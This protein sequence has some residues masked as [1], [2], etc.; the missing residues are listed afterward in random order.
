MTLHP[1]TTSLYD[2]GTSPEKTFSRIFVTILAAVRREFS[3]IYNRDL[4]SS[5]TLLMDEILTSFA[6][7][8]GNGIRWWCYGHS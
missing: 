5:M 2:W 3:S 4:A 7:A 8:I 6:H 1:T